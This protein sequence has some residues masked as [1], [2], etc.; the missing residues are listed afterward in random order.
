MEIKTL[1]K[2]GIAVLSLFLILTCGLELP[3]RA[4]TLEE[5]LSVE[6]LSVSLP[7]SW[8]EEDLNR[9]GVIYHAVC[10][11]GGLEMSIYTARS[12]RSNLINNWN[13]LPEEQLRSQAESA[14]GKERNGT[15]YDAWQLFTT[16]QLT[17]LRFDGVMLGSDES[18]TAYFSQYTTIANGGT[19]QVTFYRTDRQLSEDEQ[20]DAAGIVRSLHFDTL[21]TER[22][23]DRKIAIQLAVLTLVIL[24][25]I[26]SVILNIRRYRRKHN[27]VRRKKEN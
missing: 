11:D 14:C 21:K 4:V 10:E 6:G 20:S 25:L 12:L 26:A 17:F 2:K 16:D 7:D 8:E 5:N 13:S 1:F 18:T 9:T 3:C 22:S 27:I 23:I 15:R 24:A 19:L